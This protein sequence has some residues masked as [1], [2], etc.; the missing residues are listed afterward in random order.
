M[1]TKKS[2]VKAKAKTT[3]AAK[4]T[5][6]T[7][8][9]TVKKTAPVVTIKNRVVNLR[10]INL[11]S[12]VVFVVLAVLAGVLMKAANYE[13]TITYLTSDRLAGGAIVGAYRHFMDV[14][15]RWLTVGLLALSAVVPLLHV[16]RREA[17]YKTY[18]K[19]KVLP[20]RWVEQ[21]VL[22]AFMVTIVALLVGFQDTVEL[23]LFA[24][25]AILVSLFAWVAEYSLAYT[26][27]Y[28]LRA[29]V[30]SAVASLALI[31]YLGSALVLTYLYGQVRAS[32]FV[33][34]AFAVFSLT[35][36]V[37]SL[38]LL[39]YLT[40]N[41]AYSNYEIFER[42]HLVVSLVSKLAFAVVL[43]VGLSK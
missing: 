20:W 13:T 33:Y 30:V 31:V 10:K 6:A 39:K 21:A 15:V 35:L 18:L 1:A 14:D 29:H 16:T 42:D 17:A 4:S 12:A 5:K 32:W 43:I 22:S 37:S 3:K 28:A 41:K 38:K 26:K 11:V 27:K 23:K 7:T 34:T 9:A 19:G 36:V 2:T 8:K 40:G 24:V 25:V